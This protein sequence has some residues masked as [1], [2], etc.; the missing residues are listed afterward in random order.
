MVIHGG[1]DPVGEGCRLVER[2][3]GHELKGRTP[4][5]ASERPAGA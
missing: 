5:C 1:G 3:T 2:I 4:G